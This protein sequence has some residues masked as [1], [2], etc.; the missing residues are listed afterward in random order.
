LVTALLV[1][2]LRALAGNVGLFLARRIELNIG[3]AFLV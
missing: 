3:W 2:I 1:S